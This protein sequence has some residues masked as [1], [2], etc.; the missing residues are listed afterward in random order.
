MSSAVSAPDLQLQQRAYYNL[1]NT[2]Y[3]AGERAPEPNGKIDHWEKAVENYKAAAALDPKDADAKFNLEFVKKKLEELKKQQKQ[4][5]KQEQQKQQNKQDSDKNDK[6][7]NDKQKQDQQKQQE[8]PKPEENQHDQADQ[9]KAQDQKRQEQQQ[10]KQDKPQGNDRGE[11]KEGEPKEANAGTTPGQMTIQEAQQL[12]DSHKD[13]ERTMIFV[14]A[15]KLK[16]RK[17]VF[18][19][20]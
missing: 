18:K 11:E 2:H 14:P 8:Q 17:R 20:W 16:D 5:P 4:E 9:N 19:D 10:A 15:Q 13:E 7:K 6:Q 12:L 3:R 1:G